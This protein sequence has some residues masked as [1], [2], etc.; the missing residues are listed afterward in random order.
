MMKKC[1]LQPRYWVSKTLSSERCR[2]KIRRGSQLI[3]ILS[4]IERAMTKEEL[5]SIYLT[6][7][8]SLEYFLIPQPVLSFS[9]V[10]VLF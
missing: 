5:S 10:T 8:E 6:W 4:S 9:M 2:R 1:L 7:I 3:E